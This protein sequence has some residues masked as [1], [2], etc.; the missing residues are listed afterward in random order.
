MKAEPQNPSARST[1]MTRRTQVLLVVILV[2]GSLL[3]WEYRIQSFHGDSLARLQ[4][5]L[6]RRKTL[7]VPLTRDEVSSFLAGNPAKRSNSDATSIDYYTWRGLIHHSHISVEFGPNGEVVNVENSLFGGT[8]FAN[9]DEAP[10][11][12]APATSPQEVAAALQ[13]A[14]E[15]LRR[16]DA[17][18]WINR[19]RTEPKEFDLAL[20]GVFDGLP[21]LKVSTVKGEL[22]WNSVRIPRNGRR[23]FAFRFTVPNADPVV[24]DYVR[25]VHAQHARVIARGE[26]AVGYFNTENF[27]EGRRFDLEQ[28]VEVEGFERLDSAGFGSRSLKED[29][30]GKDFILWFDTGDDDPRSDFELKTVMFVSKEEEAPPRRGLHEICDFIGLRTN[31][32]KFLPMPQGIRDAMMAFEERLQNQFVVSATCGRIFRPIMAA[33]P[34]VTVNVTP[35]QAHWQKLEFPSGHCTAVRVHIPESIGG[36]VDLYGAYLAT[37]PGLLGWDCSDRYEGDIETRT[38]LDAQLESPLP[39]PPNRLTMMSHTHGVVEAGQDVV[40]WFFQQSEDGQQPDPAFVTLTAVPHGDSNDYVKARQKIKA[41]QAWSC[42]KLLGVTVPHPAAPAGCTV[43]GI[44]ER[45]IIFLS[46]TPDSRRLVNINER[47]TINIWDI[48]T[49]RYEGEVILPPIGNLLS[50]MVC[51]SPDSKMLLLFDSAKR[52][53]LRWSLDSREPAAALDGLTARNDRLETA[54]FGPQPHQ[55]LLGIS[56]SAGQLNS[57]M[58]FVTRD[59]NTSQT[60][61]HSRAVRGETGSLVFIPTTNMFALGVTQLLV[62]SENANSRRIKSTVQFYSAEFT[63]RIQELVLSEDPHQ[64]SAQEMIPVRL[65]Y[66]LGGRRIAAICESGGLKVWDI[67]TGTELLSKKLQTEPD[68]EHGY[69]AGLQTPNLHVSLSAD[70]ETV[71]AASPTN[72]AVSAWNVSN[73]QHRHAWQ[74]DDISVTHVVHSSDGTWV[75]T[76]N[77]DGVIRLWKNEP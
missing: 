59:L 46:F 63:N 32:P 19:Q 44:H 58:R 74:A 33:L 16:P 53:V 70:G 20:R 30:P 12:Q 21:E 10:K 45:E 39:P 17:A 68:W 60:V 9:Q 71:A 3:G 49:R 35:G 61:E 31:V 72:P 1:R 24:L 47:G 5:E 54:A 38:V 42:G 23:L 41:Q 15:L 50:D 69:M 4:S 6:E 18:V 64:F 11:F 55:L 66:H 48:E 25:T 27:R 14:E 36:K 56:Q 37:R 57:T 67:G 40:L 2:I 76:A 51:L 73:G 28:N 8:E 13:Q 29:W 77:T 26:P 65:S 62:D 43:L 34:E 75:A 52:S 22:H 7:Q